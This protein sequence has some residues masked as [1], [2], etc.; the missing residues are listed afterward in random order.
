MRNSSFPLSKSK[1]FLSCPFLYIPPL[2][3]PNNSDLDIDFFNI[4][5]STSGP[6]K[7]LHNFLRYFLRKDAKSYCSTHCASSVVGVP[8]NLYTEILLSV[9]GSSSYRFIL[10]R[11]TRCLKRLD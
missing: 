6:N 9:S 1:L 7:R 11:K 3:S 10:S 5:T 2:T 4:S 8:S